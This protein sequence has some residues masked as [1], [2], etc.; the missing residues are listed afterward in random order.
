MHSMESV[1]AT[2]TPQMIN[3]N[4]LLK[5]TMHIASYMLCMA[6][7]LIYNMHACTFMYSHVSYS[8]DRV[9]PHTDSPAFDDPP[10]EFYNY[11]RMLIENF[12]VGSN[13]V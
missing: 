8:R 1:I 3:D 7:C 12:E 2:Y 4:T 5:I 10:G 6:I 9:L 11:T 13:H